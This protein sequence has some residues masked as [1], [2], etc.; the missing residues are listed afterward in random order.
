MQEKVS[1]C[2]RGVMTRMHMEI[3]RSINFYRGQQAG[4]APS[5]ILLSGGTSIIPHADTFLAEIAAQERDENF[6]A[7]GGAA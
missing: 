5:Q 2:V 4:N 7:T 1:K 6:E 3:T